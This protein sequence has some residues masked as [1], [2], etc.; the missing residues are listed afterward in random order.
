MHKIIAFGV[1][2]LVLSAQAVAGLCVDQDSAVGSGGHIVATGESVGDCTAF[3][4]LESAEYDSLVGSVQFWNV[5]PVESLSEAWFI[6]FSL[7]MLVYLSAW[8][9][10]AVLRFIH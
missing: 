4:L 3:V 9:L 1:L 10:G 7:P 8:A 6:G 2:S 5:P